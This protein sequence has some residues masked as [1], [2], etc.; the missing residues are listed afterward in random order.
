MI[1]LV[2]LTVHMNIPDLNY[3]AHALFLTLTTAQA[4]KNMANNKVVASNKLGV[5]YIATSRQNYKEIAN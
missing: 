3:Y 5:I 1:L 4:C 2:V